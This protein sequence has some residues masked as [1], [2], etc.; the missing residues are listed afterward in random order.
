MNCFRETGTAGGHLLNALRSEVAADQAVAK[1][2]MKE[3]HSR[4]LKAIKGRFPPYS[5]WASGQGADDAVR[6]YHQRNSAPGILRGRERGDTR[7]H[8]QALRAFD[9]DVVGRDVRYRWKSTQR[10]AFIDKGPEVRVH[11][12]EPVSTLAAL[13]MAQQTLGSFTIHGTSEFKEQVAHLAVVHGFEMEGEGMEEAT[14]AVRQ[15]LGRV[16]SGEKGLVTREPEPHSRRE[17]GR[18]F[19]TPTRGGGKKQMSGLDR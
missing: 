12:L 11:D 15:R 7:A 8:P 10:V 19:A 14:A 1:R 18:P 3:C 4:E 17:R 16:Q 13:Q 2:E 9:A 5:E 6:D